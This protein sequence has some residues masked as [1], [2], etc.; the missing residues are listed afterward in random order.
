MTSTTISAGGGVLT[1][2]NVSFRLIL[3]CF[4]TDCTWPAAEAPVIYLRAILRPVLTRLQTLAIVLS[5][6]I[7]LAGGFESIFAGGFGA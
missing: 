5:A 4:L 7:I 6:G 3:G 2:S 1:Y